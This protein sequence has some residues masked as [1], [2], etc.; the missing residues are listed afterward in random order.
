MQQG[1]QNMPSSA[2]EDGSI[3]RGHPIYAPLGD[4][5]LFMITLTSWRGSFTSFHSLLM[6][7][8]ARSLAV[9]A[10]HFGAPAVLG[11]PVR[12]KAVHAPLIFSAS[13]CRSGPLPTSSGCSRTLLN[14]NGSSDVW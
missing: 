14:T 4:G 8:V 1:R 3:P 9:Y 11:F 10:S 6:I 12:A 13:G 7:M 2:Q 5:R